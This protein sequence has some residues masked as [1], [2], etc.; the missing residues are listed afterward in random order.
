MKTVYLKF[1]VSILL[2]FIVGFVIAQP[3]VDLVN[4]QFKNYPGVAYDSSNAKLG[5]RQGMGNVF[6][7][8]ELKSKDI[9]I[10]GGAYNRYDVKSIGD[11]TEKASV[12]AISLNL[13]GV[14]KWNDGKW[15]LMLVAI[16]KISS[17]FKTITMNH[18]QL[19]GAG[20]L[21]YK[22]NETLK[23]KA[24]LYYNR[25]FFGNQF[26]PL[27]GF[28]WKASDRLNIWGMLPNAM[29]LEYKISPKLYIGY[30]YKST[31]ATFRLSGNNDDYYVRD[32]HRFWGHI[33][34]KIFVNVYPA[35]NIVLFSEVGYT[36]G[37]RLELYKNGKE[38]RQ[39][40]LTNNNVYKKA[41]DG[42][43]FNL[44]IAFRVRLDNKDSQ[45][46]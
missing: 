43:F 17:D 44:G 10:L 39:T 24:G 16:P 14:K 7:P 2:T 25:E 41:Q 3:Y 40:P 37:R 26:V 46:Q 1:T 42:V 19:G 22:R 5:T 20:L 36:T 29:N 31:V 38:N 30:S 18:L 21:T 6:L 27:L 9:I 13:G 11:T 34:N 4:V 33:Q 8:L 12:S 32:G 45:T 23:L 35:K 28:E 15:A